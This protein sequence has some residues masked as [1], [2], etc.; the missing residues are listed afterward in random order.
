MVG[1]SGSLI[2]SPNAF[3]QL[4]LRRSVVIIMSTGSD[5]H[6]HEG[7]KM[8]LTICYTLPL[9]LAVPLDAFSHTAVSGA[10]LQFGGT[11]LFDSPSNVTLT[12]G[13]RE[14]VY[15]LQ[16]R[17]PV[18]N[19]IEWYNP[20][21]QLVSKDGGDAVNQQ[22]AG[23]GRIVH[24]NFQSY[25]QNQSGKYEC[26]VNV[27]GNNLERLPVC[28]GGCHAWGD[29]CGLLSISVHVALPCQSKWT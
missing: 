6:V 13:V 14:S 7:R 19:S 5:M 17:G 20:Q 29:G 22:G 27:S 28:I 24:L 8:K 23:G 21:G 11:S 12:V 2:V 3:L 25:Q 16:V 9:Y 4:H 26:R 10:Y 18:P 1:V 15:C